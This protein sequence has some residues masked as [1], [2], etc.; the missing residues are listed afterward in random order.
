MY[1]QLYN[2]ANC[3]TNTKERAFNILECKQG[4][5]NIH[6]IVYKDQYIVVRHH[7]LPAF[8]KQAQIDACMTLLKSGQKSVLRILAFKLQS[9]QP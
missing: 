2:V 9:A 5:D 3:I 6:D 1:T 7:F 4:L 8:T